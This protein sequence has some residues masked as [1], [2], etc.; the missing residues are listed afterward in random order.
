MPSKSVLYLDVLYLS[1]SLNTCRDYGTTE[2]LLF[3]TLKY[4]PVFC[5]CPNFL[6]YIHVTRLNHVFAMPSEDV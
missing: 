3:K 2:P 6:P 1:R 5:S 4:G